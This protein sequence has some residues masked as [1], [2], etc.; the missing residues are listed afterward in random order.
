MIQLL[1]EFRQKFDE[2]GS[3]FHDTATTL[4][5]N[6]DRQFT[7][8]QIAAK[9]GASKQRVSTLLDDMGSSWVVRN[10]DRTTFTWNSE[11][12]DPTDVEFGE[13]IL[14]FCSD[15]MELLRKHTQ[16]TISALAVVG[17]YLSFPNQT[18]HRWFTS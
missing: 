7:L 16:S 15:L 11:T 1:K 18:F 2:K 12:H 17:F 9:V 13:A 4:Y 3:T 8:E 6:Y 14:W 5:Q 10:E